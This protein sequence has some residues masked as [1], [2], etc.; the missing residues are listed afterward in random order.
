MSRQT[1][2]QLISAHGGCDRCNAKWTAKNAQALAA[3]HH[4]N[5][6]H[7]VWVERTDIIRYGVAGVRQTKSEQ[8]KLL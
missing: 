4:D 1:S 6:Q 7:P 5:T 3:Q 8:R 2:S